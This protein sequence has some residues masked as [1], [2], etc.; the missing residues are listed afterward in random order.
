MTGVSGVSQSKP[1]SGRGFHARRNLSPP[2]LV[3]SASSPTVSAVMRANRHR[4]TGPELALRAALAR[5][6]VRGYRVTL[7][8]LPGRP[9][10]AF[11]AAHL[12]VFVHGCFW[13][14]HGCSRSARKIP[15]ANKEFWR[16]KFTRN[17][18]RDLRKAAELRELGWTVLTVWECE[19]RK[20]AQRCALAV[21]AALSASHTSPARSIAIRAGADQGS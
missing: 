13:H 14:H 15:T 6:G 5:A 20:D 7:G 21:A 11:T 2:Q 1:K 12:A 8:E 16:A 9:D 18:Q 17:R 19:V 10:L 4:D 3:A